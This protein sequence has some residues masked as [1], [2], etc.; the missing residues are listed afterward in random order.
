MK[1]KNTQY[2]IF[3]TYACLNWNKPAKNKK[4]GTQV[5]LAIA[6]CRIMWISWKPIQQDAADIAIADEASESSFS[7][8][9]SSYWIPMWR[10]RFPEY[11]VLLTIDLLVS[12]RPFS[13]DW[14]AE[15]DP[16]SVHSN[17]YSPKQ[18][19]TL[20]KT[21]SY[22]PTAFP[23]VSGRSNVPQLVDYSQMMDL[24]M[25]VKSYNRWQTSYSISMLK[26]L[27]MQRWELLA[28]RTRKKIQTTEKLEEI[29]VG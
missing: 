10:R 29:W 19:S 6:S 7:L 4:L 17:C 24:F 3:F 23:V 11:L 25:I 13:E 8:I 16:I 9:A 1:V 20:Y 26:F 5:L 27:S 22:S 2:D 14:D 28:I 21:W 15:S 18:N 12:W